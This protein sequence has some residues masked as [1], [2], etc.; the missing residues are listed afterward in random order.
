MI[1]QNIQSV[2]SQ[3]GTGA[4]PA[5]PPRADYSAAADLNK[6]LAKYDLSA[7]VPPAQNQV[8]PPAAL[9]GPA[10][11]AATAAPSTRD[12]PAM[13]A[14]RAKLALIQNVPDELKSNG[15][16]CV[17]RYES[18][19]NSSK[20]AKVPYNPATGQR[21]DVSAPQT[22]GTYNEAVQALP[23][24][25]DGMGILIADGIVAI[26][27]DN[28]IDDQGNL[29]PMAADIVKTMAC[30]TETSPSGKGIR[31]LFRV[32][33]GFV[34]DS[35]RYY[36]NNQ[37][38]GF[39][40]YVA[41]FTKKY[42]SVT[43]STN[44]PGASL[45]DRTPQLTYVL[46]KYMRRSTPAAPE[47]PAQ[48][49]PLQP[50]AGCP[51]LSDSQIIQNIRNSRSGPLLDALLSGDMRAYGNDHSRADMA[52]CDILAAFTKDADQIDRIIR[53]SQLMRPKWDSS[54]GQSTY[55]DITI[56]KAIQSAIQY[57][58]QNRASAVAV[59]QAPL[60]EDGPIPASELMQ[61]DLPDLQWF[62]DDLI[63]EGVTLLAS[64][65]KGGKSWF[66]LLL[67]L[68]V[69]GDVPFLGRPTNCCGVLYFSLEDSRRRLQKRIG[70]LLQGTPAPNNLY[71][72]TKCPPLG[73]ALFSKLDD[74]LDKHPD[75]KLVIIDT[76]QM[77]R[78]ADSAGVYSYSGDYADIRLLKEYGMRRKVSFLLVHHVR[79]SKDES[80]PF[81]NISGTNGIAGSVDTMMVLAKNSGESNSTLHVTG[82]DV[83]SASLVL[84]MDEDTMRWGALGDAETLRQ[85]RK[86]QEFLDSP[87]VQTV[88]EVVSNSPDHTWNGLASD[89]VSAGK[90]RGRDLGS[91]GS[92]GSRLNAH[93]DG[94]RTYLGIIH[95][96]VSTNG[97]A[98]KRHFFSSI[99]IDNIE[100][101]TG[102]VP[103][104]EQ[105]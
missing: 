28:V 27:L 52:A 95:N 7:F 67:A 43:G 68:A 104:C 92:V 18:R 50:P 53:N 16:W 42:V 37:Q 41:G 69:A 21:A 24:G 60:Q 54:R 102:T 61:L 51:Q 63:L 59:Q 8:P 46:D 48:P 66:V 47:A 39:E 49:Q 55:G 1:M 57:D 105:L 82:K 26:D 3:A 45:V 76:L 58:M 101:S 94:F 13:Q 85:E 74:Y 90:A 15:R 40:V 70:L 84:E 36:I 22:F 33:P 12:T 25:Y 72:E 87:L 96:A 32:A 6:I 30:Y 38:L 23:N 44:M 77:V 64:E 9:P 34:F 81:A 99:P 89:L 86:K 56:T 93:A 2:S 100:N 20:P 62:V 73:D 91:A 4:N 83:S 78:N 103:D 19:P 29:S 31:I 97:N 35:T 80:N 10:T 79:K 11:V 5:R 75:I 65:P 71:L 17:W 14:C 98:G 88:Y